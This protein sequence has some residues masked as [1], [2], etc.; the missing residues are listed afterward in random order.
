[1]TT[2]DEVE[3]LRPGFDVTWRG[4]DRQEVQSYLRCVETELRLLTAEREAA[5]AHAS[6]VTR[7]LE[8]VAEENRDL[9]ARIDRICRTPIEPDGLA[10]RLGRMVELAKEEA[11]ALVSE[12]AEE[13]ATT[14]ERVAAQ[15][16]EAQAHL[17]ALTQSP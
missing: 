7:I 11:V 9:R 10:E 15:L 5:R 12:A 6:D 3:E 17:A 8:A 4:Y 14:R 13:A 1:M 2:A 16:R